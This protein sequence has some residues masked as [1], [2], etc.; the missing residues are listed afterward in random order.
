MLL[1]LCPAIL[2]LTA[3]C[4]AQQVNWTGPYRPCD[5]SAELT[6]TGHLNIGVR[7][8]ISDPVLIQEFHEAFAFWSRFLD[9]DFY[10]DQSS[11]C[12]VAIV[13]ATGKLLGTSAVAR[14][15][16]PDRGG[17]GGLIAI[18]PAANTYLSRGEA[19]AAW[20]HE[21]GHLLGLRHNPSPASLMY[22][23]DVDPSSSLDSSDLSALSRLHAL[24][25]CFRA[26]N[27]G[28]DRISVV[29]GGR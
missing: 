23:I 28:V 11:S 6:R 2:A 1:R 29:T 20:T 15:Q 22:F 7:Y 17:F 21:I 5:N 25:P 18:D 9:A 16:F 8:D 14:A 4:L 13:S 24:R 27:A 12:A 3:T 26:S 10:A 19:V